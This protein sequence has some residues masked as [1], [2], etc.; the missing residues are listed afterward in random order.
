[1]AALPTRIETETGHMLTPAEIFRITAA[2]ETTL[3]RLLMLYIITGLVFMLLPGTFLGVWNLITISSQRAANSVS[4]AWI[5]AHGHAQIFGRIGTFILGIGLHSIPKMRRLSWLR[6]S[7]AGVAWAF[8]T[9]GVTLRWISSV[10]LWHW[11]LLSPFSALLE[12]AAFVL[13]LHSVS[14]HRAARSTNSNGEEWVVAVIAGTSGLLL[15][16]LMNA[17]AT[18]YLA[19]Y[20]ASPELPPVFNQRFL[21]LQTWSFSGSLRV[22]IQRQVA[23]DFSWPRA[24]AQPDSDSCSRPELCWRG[25]GARRMERGCNVVAPLRNLRRDLCPAAL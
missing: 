8:W 3:S 1:M 9:S 11:R 15:A 23:A 13:F 19:L 18:L 12:L 5:Q 6:L 7:S 24:G 17:G 16:L 25:G 14:R 10:Y 21:L 4:P 22:G 20:G 2:R